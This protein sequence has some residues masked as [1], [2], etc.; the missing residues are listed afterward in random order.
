MMVHNNSNNKL[1]RFR[2]INYSNILSIHL[3]DSDVK[4]IACRIKYII[5]VTQK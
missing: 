4:A 3:R 5:P 1:N 2:R